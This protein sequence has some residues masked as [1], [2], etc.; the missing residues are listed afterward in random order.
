MLHA[1]IPDLATGFGYGHDDWMFS[2]TK[3]LLAKV[4]VLALHVAIPSRLVNE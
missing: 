4:A 1:D 3:L 2:H